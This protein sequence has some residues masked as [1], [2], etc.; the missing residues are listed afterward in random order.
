MGHLKKIIWAAVLAFALITQSAAKEDGPIVRI[1]AIDWCPQLCPNSKKRGYIYDIVQKVYEGTS[2]NLVI[3]TMPWSR[4]IKMTE[5]GTALALLSPAKAEAPHLLYPQNAVGSQSMC[6]FTLSTNPW[7]YEGEASLK[8]LRIGIANDTSI[9]EL[10]A[11]VAQN[12]SQFQFQPYSDKYII[13]SLRKLDYSRIDTFLF[14]KNT[15]L[16]EI[17]KIGW[18]DRYRLAGCVSKAD[19]YMAFSPNQAVRDQVDPLMTVFEQK[20]TQI[21]ESG[22]FDRILATYGLQP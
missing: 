22:E 21:Y 18:S 2:Y 4:A 1:A 14:T 13:S 9:E 16:Y 12:K 19:I 17:D 8:G 3:E 5:D 7:R 15:T 11:Y 20:M 6:F 10:N